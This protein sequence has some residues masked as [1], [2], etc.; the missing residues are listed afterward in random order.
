[1]A[2]FGFGDISFSKGL[3]G[4][5]GPLASLEQ[6]N[7]SV[8]TLR[9]PLDIGN[10]DKGHYMIF[11]IKKQ[12]ASQASDENTPTSFVEAINSATKNSINSSNLYNNNYNLSVNVSGSDASPSDIANI[13]I[14]KIRTMDNRRVR[15]NRY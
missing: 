15:G 8:S 14:Q 7:Y 10:A 12:E 13:V 6:S 1:M 5:R 3:S 11:Y 2:L 9:Y 4:R